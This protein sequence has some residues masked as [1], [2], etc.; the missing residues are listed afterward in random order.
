MNLDRPSGIKAIILERVLA[1]SISDSV[2]VLPWQHP[3]IMVS[4]DFLGRSHVS[5]SSRS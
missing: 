5:S 2:V 1:C 3:S 4:L